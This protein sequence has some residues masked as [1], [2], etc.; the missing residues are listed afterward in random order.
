MFG[1]FFLVGLGA[2]A[3][4]PEATRILS[5]IGCAGVAFL[6]TISLPGLLAGYGML[7]RKSWARILGIIVAILDLFNVPIGTAIGLYGLW[8]LTADEAVD[9]FARPGPA[10]TG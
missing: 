9:Y 7:T 4:D 3:D 1:F 10:A 5:F 6:T 2:V 8:V